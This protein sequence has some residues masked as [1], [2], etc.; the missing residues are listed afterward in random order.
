MPHPARRP[1]ALLVVALGLIPLAIAAEEPN[2]THAQPELPRETLTIITHDGKRHEFHVEMAKTADQQT[3]G[4]MFRT[5][6]A[7][8]EGMLFDWGIPRESQMWMKNTLVPLDMV[9]INEDGSIRTIAENTVPRSLAV[10]ASHGPVRATLELAA[11]VTEK[12]DIRVGDRVV[13]GIFPAKP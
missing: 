10:I 2:I 12:D 11:G 7:D 9:F 1:L 5:H 4:L 6:V 8:D 13:G 3:I